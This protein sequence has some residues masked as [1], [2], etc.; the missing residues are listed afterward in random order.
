MVRR[1]SLIGHFP[2]LYYPPVRLEH[3]HSPKRLTLTS[4]CVPIAEFKATFAETLPTR[5]SAQCNNAVTRGVH[6]TRR[7]GRRRVTGWTRSGSCEWDTSDSG[8]HEVC[9]TMSAQFL[10][11]SATHDD[12][13]LSSV[14][15][16]GGHW[17]ICAWAFAVRPS[18]SPPVSPCHPSLRTSTRTCF[19][20]RH[21]TIW[22]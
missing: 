10:A 3:P 17:C 20:T 22:L 12:N 1:W 21:A 2:I 15:G 14:V 13:D 6:L 19:A 11:N 8:Y 4:G 5:D 7:V 16:A 9:V 18:P